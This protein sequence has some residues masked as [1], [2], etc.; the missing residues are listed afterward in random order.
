MSLPG[1]FGAEDTCGDPTFEGE[2]EAGEA[3]L[4]GSFHVSMGPVPL[5]L[6]LLLPP[7]CEPPKLVPLAVLIDGGE[8]GGV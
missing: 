5:V 3:I 6:D 8:D 2:D 1:E 7:R 4:S